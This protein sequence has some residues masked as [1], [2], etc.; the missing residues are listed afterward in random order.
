ML[1]VSVSLPTLKRTTTTT[2]GCLS[3]MRRRATD[4]SVASRHVYSG[5]FTSWWARAH[6][7]RP[8]VCT[9]TGAA[10]KHWPV[11]V[12]HTLLHS[13]PPPPPPPP[14]SAHCVCVRAHS[15]RPPS[16]PPPLPFT[17]LFCVVVCQRRCLQPGP[18]CVRPLLLIDSGPPALGVPR[19]P[20]ATG[21]RKAETRAPGPGGRFVNNTHTH[22][23]PRLPSLAAVD[24]A[25]IV[26]SVLKNARWTRQVTA[27]VAQL[28][29]PNVGGGGV[30]R[31]C[32]CVCMCPL[33][34]AKAARRVSSRADINGG[35]Y[36]PIGIISSVTSCD[37]PSLR[38]CADKVFPAGRLSGRTARGP[39][40][41][42]CSRSPAGFEVVV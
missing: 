1:D 22:T 7:S 33:F 25:T 13:S 35:D 18:H 14:P 28:Q 34:K 32:V 3:V 12:R 37:P 42:H 30:P 39:P 40:R 23:Q 29:L 4:A 36:S 26:A 27:A 2:S 11:W 24:L 5:V 21:G 8:R 19:A 38:W 17:G 16:P 31:V 41:C 10:T 6:R 9:N 20:Q 15:C